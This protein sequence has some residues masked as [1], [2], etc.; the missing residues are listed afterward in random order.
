MIRNR[1]SI[2]KLYWKV[3]YLVHFAMYRYLIKF[4]LIQ[5]SILWCGRMELILIQRLYMIGLS[6]FLNLNA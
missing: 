6:I 4:G 3:S 2:S 1:L 5:R